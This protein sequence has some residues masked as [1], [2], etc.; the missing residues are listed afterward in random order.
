MSTGMFGGTLV[1]GLIGLS[2]HA[3][4]AC[5]L[6]WGDYEVAAD[7][8]GAAELH[9]QCDQSMLAFQFDVSGMQLTGI[10]DGWCG[11]AGWQLYSGATTAIGFTLGQPPMPPQA[12]LVHMVTIDFMVTGETLAF[13]EEVIFVSP[14]DVVIDVDWSDTIELDGCAADVYPEGG[15]DGVVGVDEIL[16]L[17]GDWGGTGSPFDINGDGLIG[18]DD[19]LAVLEAWGPCA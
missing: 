11:E 9:W 4:A 5:V 17:L 10:R 14:P 13:A 1:L 7:G 19:L 8:T 2:T 3:F 6:E 18:V 16:A 12:D 15:G